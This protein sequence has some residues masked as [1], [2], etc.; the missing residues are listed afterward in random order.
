MSLP[1]VTHQEERI[2]AG[3]SMPR[4]LIQAMALIAKKERLPASR[5]IANELEKIAVRKLGAEVVERLK[6]DPN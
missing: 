4:Y 5:L 2:Q 3:W 6:E 1:R